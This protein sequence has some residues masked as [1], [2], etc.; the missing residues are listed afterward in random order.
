[1]KYLAILAL[2]VA[3]ALA[4]NPPAH[5][6]KRTMAAQ[7]DQGFSIITAKHLEERRESKA[8]GDFRP[9]NIFFNLSLLNIKLEELEMT[10]MIPFYKKVFEAASAWWK[11]AL[12]VNDDKSKI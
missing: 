6:V 12:K 11:N 3:Q 7:F 4:C 2:I 8:N 10:E 9:L 1:M 5:I